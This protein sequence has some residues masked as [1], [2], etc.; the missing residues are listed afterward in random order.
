M[1]IGKQEVT[2]P[3]FHT[4]FVYI[5]SPRKSKAK[6][7]EFVIEFSRG[8]TF[9]I[10]I[11]KSMAFLYTRNKQQEIIGKDGWYGLIPPET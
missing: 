3:L 6:W 10:N 1:R 4:L 2:L 11:Q 8:T 5:T 9:E 7:S